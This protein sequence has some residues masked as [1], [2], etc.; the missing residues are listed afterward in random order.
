MY[1]TDIMTVAAN[2]TGSPAVSL[3]CGDVDGL[4]VGLQLI[5]AQ[6]HDRQLL[7]LAHAVEGL[8]A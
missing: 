6:R 7:G 3:P 8:L 2:L 4:P 5:A 1:L